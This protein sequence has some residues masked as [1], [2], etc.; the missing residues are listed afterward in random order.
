MDQNTAK[1]YIVLNKGTIETIY[2]ED[3][4]LPVVV[5]DM[6]TIQ[7]EP[8]NIRKEIEKWRKDL[9]TNVLSGGILN[10]IDYWEAKELL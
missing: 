6:D 2:S 1:V 5:L 4:S 10:E 3:A 7:N 9:K 8:D